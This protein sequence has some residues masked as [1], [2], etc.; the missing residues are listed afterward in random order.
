MGEGGVQATGEGVL[1]LGLV[2]GEI[3]LLIRWLGFGGDL[4]GIRLG[5]DL[6]GFG[7]LGLNGFG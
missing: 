6:I 3:R 5:S 2:I 1:G 4:G 7:L